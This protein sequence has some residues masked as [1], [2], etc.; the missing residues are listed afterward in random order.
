MKKKKTIFSKTDIENLICDLHKLYPKLDNENILINQ[1]KEYI[2]QID[3]LVRSSLFKKTLLDLSDSLISLTKKKESDF[4]GRLKSKNIQLKNVFQELVVGN[5]FQNLKYKVTYQPNYAFEGHNNPD[6]EIEKQ[7]QKAIIEVFTLNQYEDYENEQFFILLLTIR[8]KEIENKYNVIFDF[9]RGSFDIRSIKEGNINDCI[10]KILTDV[11]LWLDHNSNTKKNNHHE[12]HFGL[13]IIALHISNGLGL[14]H[15]M[16]GVGA[17]SDRLS[18]PIIKKFERY[19]EL[20][21]KNKTPFIIACITDNLHRLNMDCFRDIIFEI[22][23]SSYSKNKVGVINKQNK[24]YE[25]SG[26]MLFDL[27][28]DTNQIDYEYIQNPNAK[29]PIELMINKKSSKRRNE[30]I[31]LLL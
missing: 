30:N 4:I 27:N 31:G 24:L 9:N 10:N 7:T 13:E 23:P 1:L 15:K 20:I 29:Y 6:W 22:P 11:E 19:K 25:V 8:L 17:H 16:I 28:V 5:F 26:F 14:N 18:D 3:L 21:K 2:L 12:T